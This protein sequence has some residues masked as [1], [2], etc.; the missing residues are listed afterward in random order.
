MVLVSFRTIY[1]AA[2]EHRE[3]FSK[4]LSYLFAVLILI[5]WGFIQYTCL[6]QSYNDYNQASQERELSREVRTLRRAGTLMTD[7]QVRALRSYRQQNAITSLKDKIIYYGNIAGNLLL[8]GCFV[9]A[10][11]VLLD[12]VVANANA[13]EWEIF[14]AEMFISLFILLTM[15]FFIPLSGSLISHENKQLCTIVFIVFIPLVVVA[16]IFRGIANNP[17][18]VT[19]VKIMLIAIPMCGLYM[20]SLNYVRKKSDNIYKAYLTISGF[21]FIFPW[22]LSGTLYFLNFYELS[23]PLVVA[24]IVLFGVSVLII[25]VFLLVQIIMKIK[26]TIETGYKFDDCNFSTMGSLVNSSGGIIGIGILMYVYATYPESDASRR[27]AIL[28]VGF[29]ILF[30]T[31]CLNIVL[32]IK[33]PKEIVSHHLEYLFSEREDPLQQHYRS[34]QFWQKV[35][36]V[37]GIFALPLLFLILY[38]IISSEAEKAFFIV[39]I[40]ASL[41]AATFFLVLLELRRKIGVYSK[42]CL[43][44]CTSCIWLFVLLPLLVGAPVAIIYLGTSAENYQKLSGYIITFLCIVLMIGV[45]VCAIVV[46]YVFKQMEVE[47][48][49]KYCVRYLRLTLSKIAVRGS[50]DL[51]RMLYDQYRLHGESVLKEALTKGAVVFWWPIPDRDPDPK[52]NR[53]LLDSEQYQKLKAIAE[54]TKMKTK[55]IPVEN[56]EK[57]K[58]KPY[59]YFCSWC[60]ESDEEDEDVVTVINDKKENVSKKENLEQNIIKVP[61]KKEEDIIDFKALIDKLKE[62]EETPEQDKYIAGLYVQPFNALL[63]GNL[64]IGTPKQKKKKKWQE[65]QRIK[66]TWIQWKAGTQTATNYQKYWPHRKNA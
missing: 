6:H 32:R 61:T 20:G 1:Y 26:E 5:L 50:E 43:P 12:E 56:T 40:I 55:D 37:V 44:L 52:H 49:A 29:F 27:S 53:L 39:M 25:V 3:S 58:E 41:L 15:I 36:I 63:A 46:N 23:H 30:I 4:M 51:L 11:A 31:V 7:N 42:N 24:G 33:V 60:Y 19:L 18:L 66:T 14:A 65:E 8:G 35:G 28:A 21:G 2:T 34:E 54:K 45:T 22:I 48:K 62:Q 47:R 17:S 9:A 64:D 16:A 59:K 10:E 57:K 38:F 13:K